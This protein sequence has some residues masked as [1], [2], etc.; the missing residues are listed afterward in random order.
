MAFIV[1]E[2][3]EME[4]LKRHSSVRL[5]G[6]VGCEQ[7]RDEGLYLHLEIF[8]VTSIFSPAVTEVVDLLGVFLKV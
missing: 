5:R 2:N 4:L 6:L 8:S 3:N 1:S 7:C